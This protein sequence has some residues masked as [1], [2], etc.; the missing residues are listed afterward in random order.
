[1]DAIYPVIFIDLLLLTYMT[2][3]MIVVIFAHSRWSRFECTEPLGIFII[4]QCSNIIIFRF[5]YYLERHY[6]YTRVLAMLTQDAE[7]EER[8]RAMARI[9]QGL[10]Y[11]A[12]LGFLVLTILATLW[13][14][15]DTHSCN[16]ALRSDLRNWLILSWCICLLY[17]VIDIWSRKT[18]LS[19]EYDIGWVHRLNSLGALRLV[20][21]RQEEVQAGLSE[22]QI[23]SIEKWQLSRMEELK[24]IVTWSEDC[25][26]SDEFQPVCAICIEQIKVDEWY[27][28]LPECEHYFHADCIDVWLRLRDSCPLCRQTVEIPDL[29][30]ISDVSDVETALDE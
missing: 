11:A 2:F 20:V 17:F 23:Q 12:S 7:Q 13:F 18:A 9:I 30:M 16:F 4:V 6:Q 5:F 10:K 19:S 3:K 14:L 1:M 24:M 28:Q 26:A 15:Q 8:V 27:K 29:E 21:G 25:E 22:A